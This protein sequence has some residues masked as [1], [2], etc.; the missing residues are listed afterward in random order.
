[1]AYTFI[2]LSQTDTRQSTRTWHVGRWLFRL[3]VLLLLAIP[4]GTFYA[5]VH[6]FS[7]EELSGKVYKLQRDAIVLKQEITNLESAYEALSDERDQLEEQLAEQNR[8]RAE[9]QARIAM[10]DNA[11][12]NTSLQLQESRETVND[13]TRRVRV[14]ES[15]IDPNSEQ[16]PVQCYRIEAN[17]RGDTLRYGVQFLKTDN[18]DDR[19]MDL[20]VQFRVVSGPSITNLT[21]SELSDDDKV[22]KT[23][24]V[25]HRSISGTIG[26][27]VAEEGMRILDIKAYEGD[28]LVSQ[29][30]KV[31]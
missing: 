22:R 19:V 25:S 20:N 21:E 6:L 12:A 26:A 14:Y 16:L 5:G 17:P 31:F 7:A 15:L 29:C 3:L 2:F 1:M 8:E 27:K 30:W 9:A 28:N 13:L 23:D 10:I 11:R 18:K 4:F 24:I